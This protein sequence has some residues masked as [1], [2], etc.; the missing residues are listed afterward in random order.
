MGRTAEIERY[1][2][3]ESLGGLAFRAQTACHADATISPRIKHTVKSMH[4]EKLNATV[5]L[6]LILEL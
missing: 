1:G 4:R 5:T 3:S 2:L 6:L